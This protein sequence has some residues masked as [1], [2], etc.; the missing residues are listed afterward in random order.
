MQNF[1]LTSG[2]AQLT[3]NAQGWLTPTAAY[4]VRFLQRPE[5]ALVAE[6]CAAEIKLHQALKLAPLKVVPPSH[7]ARIKDEDARQNYRVFLNFRDS[8][9]AADTLEAY[10][11]QL[12]TQGRISIPPDFID[13]LAQAIL[14]NILRDADDAQQL[15][16]AQMLFRPQRITV[17]DGQ[18]LAADQAEVDTHSATGGLGE[19]G[20]FLMENKANLRGADWQI[21]NADNATQYWAQSERHRF[22]LDLTHEITQELSHGLTLRMA[23]ARSGLQALARVL[24]LWVQHLHGVTVRI[25]PEQSVSDSAWRWHVG[26][27]VESSAILN[28]LYEDKTV[29]PARLARLISLFRLTFANPQDAQ[30]ELASKPVYLGLAMNQEGVLRIKP[31]NLLLNLPL[32][33]AAAS[34]S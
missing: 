12:F 3:R 11:C 33:A 31:Q 18:V 7:V 2:Y 26:L 32:A 29:E 9:I 13:A 22:V 14:H 8:L 5:L 19:L 30:P 1:W 25:A 17:Q 21:L 23:R 10:Y 15:R 20:R 6:S 24:E 16:A 27:D 28:D 4:F 34:L